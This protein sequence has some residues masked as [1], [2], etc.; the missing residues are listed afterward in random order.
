MHDESLVRTQRAIEF[1]EANGLTQ[2]ISF[3]LLIKVFPDFGH[4]PAVAVV[5]LLLGTYPA[6]IIASHTSVGLCV[7]RV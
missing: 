2:L 4:Q 1:M 6:N 5:V 3:T 7:V